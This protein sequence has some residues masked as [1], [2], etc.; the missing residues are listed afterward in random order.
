V[1]ITSNGGPV[2]LYRNDVGNGYH[3]IRFR[4]RGTASN[5]DGIGARVRVF[6]GDQRYWRMVKT[7][8][9]YLSQSELPLTFGLG[10]RTRADRIVIDWPSGA[11]S[12]LTA[13]A[14]GVSYEITE[15]KGVTAQRPL[16]K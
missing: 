1:L 11:K 9:S 5:R 15:G 7:G 8:S 14:A 13:L 12:D 10:T 4:L 3:P 2:H 6:A 16:G